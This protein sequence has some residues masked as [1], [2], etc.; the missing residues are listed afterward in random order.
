MAI[1]AS[2]AG[3]RLDPIA[4]ARSKPPREVNSLKSTCKPRAN[5]LNPKEIR[6]DFAGRRA[7]AF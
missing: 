2:K 1:A 3:R 6:E 5:C 4:K 7:D